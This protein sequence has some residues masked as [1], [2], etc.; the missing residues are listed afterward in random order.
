MKKV[1]NA[2]T[3]TLSPVF[4]QLLPFFNVLQFKACRGSFSDNSFSLCL[5]KL[6]LGI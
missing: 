6:K 3:I 4:I 1:H 5:T 2:R